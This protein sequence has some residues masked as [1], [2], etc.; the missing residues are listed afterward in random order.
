[1]EVKELWNKATNI[2]YL[3][4][5]KNEQGKHSVNRWFSII[6]FSA[7]VYAF[8]GES[9]SRQLT[10]LDYLMF[11]LGAT[12]CYAPIMIKDILVELTPLFQAL[13][14]LKLGTKPGGD[15]A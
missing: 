1:M 15:N 9:N 8:I 10:P 13:V 6:M 5:T 11:P 3:S 12:F 4:I 2:D 7:L 14:S